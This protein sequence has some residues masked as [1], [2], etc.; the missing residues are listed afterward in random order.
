MFIIERAL[1]IFT[2]IYEMEAKIGL[3]ESRI[4]KIGLESSVSSLNPALDGSSK[5][6]PSCF[7]TGL[8]PN[9]LVLNASLLNELRQDPSSGSK[10]IPQ[11]SGDKPNKYEGKSEYSNY[12][13]YSRKNSE[14]KNL[15]R[16][17]SNSQANARKL[18]FETAS[19]FE[20]VQIKSVP[21]LE[22]SKIVSPS[23]SN[24]QARQNFVSSNS[25]FY[26]QH[27]SKHK[28]NIQ[29]GK[30]DSKDRNILASSPRF[31]RV[32]TNLVDNSLN[33][34]RIQNI[35]KGAAFP[36]TSLQPR[37][38]NNTNVHGTSWRTVWP[39]S[40]L[41]S[42]GGM[43]DAI[44]SPVSTKSM[45]KFSPA[46]PQQMFS[47]SSNSKINSNV[48]YTVTP[49]PSVVRYIEQKSV[50]G[51]ASPTGFSPLASPTYRKNVSQSK[52]S[53]NASPPN[54]NLNNLTFSYKG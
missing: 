34:H 39:N 45:N 14:S 9:Q 46:S 47:P 49:N 15:A 2:L 28:P 21:N 52:S 44:A 53:S 48:K 18:D 33:S 42:N 5:R 16:T 38:Y 3:N 27:Q 1:S 24:I 40:N 25:S 13:Q 41:M 51:L 23:A 4:P 12:K 26:Y 7:N 36:A 30:V 35:A 10:S 54:S 43:S 31:V 50:E 6:S 11:N 8:I 22:L 19:I 29:E 37:V 17:S 20:K 32:N